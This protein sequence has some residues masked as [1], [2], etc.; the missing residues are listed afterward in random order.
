[1]DNKIRD[2]L[3][4]ARIDGAFSAMCS[5]PQ[6]ASLAIDEWC[7]KKPNSWIA[8]TAR[9]YL[10]IEVAWKHRGCDWAVNVPSEKMRLFHENLRMAETALTTAYELNPGFPFAATEMITV[11]MGLC[12]PRAEMEKWFQRATTAKTSSPSANRNKVLYLQPKWHGSVEELLSFA[13]EVD[14]PDTPPLT[15]ATTYANIWYNMPNNQ[16]STLLSNP[17]YLR[18]ATLAY[19]RSLEQYP[20]R[21]NQHLFCAFFSLR[22]GNYPL[23]AKHFNRF[24]WRAKMPDLF[25]WPSKTAF[26]ADRALAFSRSPQ[27]INHRILMIWMLG[28][29]AGGFYIPTLV[30]AIR[31][32]RSWAD[33]LVVGIILVFF[34][35]RLNGY[36]PHWGTIGFVIIHVLAAGHMIREER[37]ER[38]GHSPYRDY[39]G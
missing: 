28:A 7:A 15:V 25:C 33:T 13:D 8:Y 10:L 22:S 16:K 37:Q 19:V 20:Y 17:K 12:K 23:A 2:P 26:E 21:R 14:C 34:A 6:N 18:N 30:R 4:R 35:F 32:G 38:R 24:E 1:M 39:R 29:V 5:D 3:E 36:L 31:Q 9:G 27:T 11:S